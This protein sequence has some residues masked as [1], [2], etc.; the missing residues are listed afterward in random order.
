MSQPASNASAS[1][2]RSSPRREAEELR[3]VADAAAT[4][5]YA[6]AYNRDAEFYAFTKSLETYELTMDPSTI[7]ILGTD[8]EL[9]RFL[10]Q[11]R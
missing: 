8:S 1:S 7:F 5:I 9:L 10:E 6:E 3:G 11:P 2:R 4:G